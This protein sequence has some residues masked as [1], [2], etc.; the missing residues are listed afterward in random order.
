MPGGVGAILDYEHKGSSAAMS[1]P[2]RAWGYPSG[3][4]LLILFLETL[5]EN[6]EFMSCIS[7][8]CFRVSVTANQVSP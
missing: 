1:E 5:L 4:I 6:P 2:E 8:C 3:T 7:P